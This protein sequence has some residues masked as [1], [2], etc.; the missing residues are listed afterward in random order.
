MHCRRNFRNI[1]L[2]CCWGMFQGKDAAMKYMLYILLEFV[3]FEIEGW[4]VAPPEDL[5][6]EKKRIISL[7]QKMSGNDGWGNDLSNAVAKHYSYSVFSKD[8]CAMH[9]VWKILNVLALVG[10][11]KSIDFKNRLIISGLTGD[12]VYLARA[13]FA[14]DASKQLNNAEAYCWKGMLGGYFLEK[15]CYP[16][17]A[18]YMP[19]FLAPG[20]APNQVLLDFKHNHST[21]WA[22]LNEASDAV[23]KQR[24][25]NMY[26]V[27][28]AGKSD[29]SGIEAEYIQAI[30]EIDFKQLTRGPL[31]SF[32]K[33][34]DSLVLEPE[35]ETN[36][37][38]IASLSTGSNS[39]RKQSSRGGIFNRS[40]EFVEKCVEDAKSVLR[41]VESSM[42]VKNLEFFLNP[43]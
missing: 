6:A 38:Q 21:V 39:S 13:G 35:D 41:C 36:I 27:F 26:A 14:W 28:F 31:V 42:K 33:V 34:P 11:E 2:I 37:T 12:N 43:I 17:V 40:K 3:L 7:V 10:S 19:L 4:G 20:T 23:K 22:A 8:Y 18:D 29:T 9:D 1:L 5:E 15:S 25:Q 32:V 24:L 16:K 30:Y